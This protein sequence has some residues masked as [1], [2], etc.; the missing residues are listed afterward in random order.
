MT[1]MTFSVYWYKYQRKMS[2]STCCFL[3]SCHSWWSVD[4][5]ICFFQNFTSEL[6]HSVLKELRNVHLV[7]HLETSCNFLWGKQY[8]YAIPYLE[9]M[10]LRKTH[11]QYPKPSFW[12]FK[13]VHHSPLHFSS[14]LSEVSLATHLWSRH[15][16]FQPFLQ[17][18]SRLTWY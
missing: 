16:S 8:L 6:Q 18:K 15:L 3:M 11:S 17:M 13:S 2:H 4:P 7:W 5:S 10:A 14:F 1:V 9:L 12:L